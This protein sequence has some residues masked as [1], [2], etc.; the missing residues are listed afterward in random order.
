MSRLKWLKRCAATIAALILCATPVLGE[1][2]KAE[3]DKPIVLKT[4]GSLLFGGTV[5]QKENGETFHGDHGYAQFY[6]PLHSRTYPIILWHGIGQSGRSFESTPDSREGYQ[7]ILPRRD[8]S[9]Y[10][11]D[12]PRRGR[13]GR[14]ESKMPEGNIPTT[15]R[16]SGVWNA[17]RMGRWTPPDNAKLFKGVKLPHDGYT[18]DQF[19]RQQT[20][21]TGELPQTDEHRRFM[22]NTMKALLEKTGPAILLTHSHSGQFGWETGILAPELVKAIVAYEPGQHVFPEGDNAEKIFTTNPDVAKNLAL[23][24]VPD[25]EFDNLTKMP[26][27]LI[28]GDNI[29]KEPSEVFNEEVWRVSLANAKQFVDAVNR[30]G[31]DATLIYLPDMGVYGNTHAAFADTNNLEIA[32]IMEKWLK[33]KGLDGHKKPHKGPLKPALDV[34]IPLDET[35]ISPND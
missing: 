18:I 20:C 7:A 27:L 3:N 30:H 15:T 21:D 16:E 14:T 8:W 34:S 17:F 19:M 13:A 10:I 24:I 26:I 31:G 4:M 2:A 25:A 5:T 22:G 33:E 9:I 35:P 29:R 28:Y 12:Q 6:I 32:D 23:Q 1:G 11:I